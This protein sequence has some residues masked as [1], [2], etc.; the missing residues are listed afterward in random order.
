MLRLYGGSNP[1][2]HTFKTYLVVEL[3]SIELCV[4][5]FEGFLDLFKLLLAIA[6]ACVPLL[7]LLDSIELGIQFAPNF[8]G[9][10]ETAFS[11]FA[12]EFKF[13][14]EFILGPLAALHVSGAEGPH[15]RN[16]RVDLAFLGPRPAAL[17]WGHRL[18]FLVASVRPHF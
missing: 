6:I 11:Y 14:G 7:G 17:R 10:P 12:N 15:V 9:L 5:D 16:W 2:S 13:A 1:K 18:E 8:V 3:L 4:G